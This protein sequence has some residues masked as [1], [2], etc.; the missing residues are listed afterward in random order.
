MEEFEIY[1]LASVDEWLVEEIGR[2]MPQLSAAQPPSKHL[3]SEILTNENE[4]VVVVK[5]DDPSVLVGFG[6]LCVYVSPTGYHAHIEDVVVDQAERGKGIGEQIVNALLSLAH[7]KGLDG[8]SL[9]CN[10]RREAAQRLYERIGFK[11][12][13]TNNYW[14]DL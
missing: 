13:D 2:L 9:T 12:W 4:M 14:F 5:A 6:T 8:V 3:L 1:C 7:E 10:P 11:K